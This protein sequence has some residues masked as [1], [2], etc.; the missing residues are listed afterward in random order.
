MFSIAITGGIA[1][2]KSEV[3]RLLAAHGCAVWDADMAAR[4]LLEPGGAAYEQVKEVFGAGIV[5]DAG[6]IDRRRLAERV[7]R[8]RESLEQLNG[9]VHPPVFRM[10]DAWLET[11]C[12]WRET[13]FAAVELPLL[14]ECGRSGG[15]DAVICVAAAR[16]VQLE[17]LKVRGV[18]DA[19]AD[20]MLEA[21]IALTE[22]M[23]W[24]DV[25]LI[26]NGSL[27][28]LRR[29]TLH[30]FV[31]IVKKENSYGDKNTG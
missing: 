19:M 28:G 3:A 24:A 11:I 25:V 15:W 29:Q 12:R 21:Q 23:R 17:R 20:R 18:T 30:W 1:C 27:E 10:L 9:I 16:D 26:N 31:K 13:G 8:D 2:G 7:F 5:D 14:Y 22:K 6:L 4:S